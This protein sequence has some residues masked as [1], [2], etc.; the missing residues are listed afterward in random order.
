M[1]QRVGY[2]MDLNA[3]KALVLKIRDG[4]EKNS[5]TV[6]WIE[7]LSPA[8]APSGPV[9]RELSRP[10]IRLVQTLTSAQVTLLTARLPDMKTSAMANALQGIVVREKGGSFGDWVIDFKANPEKDGKRHSEYKNRVTA[11]Y[12]PQDLVRKLY[13]AAREWGWEPTGMFPGYLALEQFLRFHQPEMVNADGWS[14]VYL[15]EGDRFMCVGNRQSLLFARGLP[16]DLSQGREEEEYFERLMTEIERSTFFAKQTDDQMVVDRIIICGKPSLADRLAERMTGRF[17]ERIT[18]WKP[19]DLFYIRQGEES[20]KYTLCLVAAAV[21]LWG[22]QYNLL[23]PEAKGGRARKI[24]RYALL[25]AGVWGV[26]VV[27]TILGGGLWTTR[28]QD[29]YLRNTEA[30]HRAW[31]ND[32]AESAT[33]AYIH[34]HALRD[35]QG[36]LDRL[37]NSHPELD[38]LLMEVARRTP[39]GIVFEKL[40]I[41]DGSDH[42][43][44]LILRGRSMARDGARAQRNFLRLMESLGRC[45]L[46]EEFKEPSRLEIAGTDDDDRAGSQ[47]AFTLE[48]M[49]RGGDER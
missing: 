11:L 24:R 41:V 32:R 44:H 37:V 2:S 12:T 4:R 46:L 6:E 31:L 16:E 22:P 1:K 40:D 29:K 35:C 48:Y 39:P 42:R 9:L 13:G 20:W 49:I 47:A 19:E 3:E 34:G 23:P 17:P 15:G 7:R 25:A 27:P 14:L 18:R 38:R 33:T 5:Y 30:A 28:V 10:R 21:S 36:N 8:A 26:A 45:A 43:F